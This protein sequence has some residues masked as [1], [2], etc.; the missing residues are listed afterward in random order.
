[1]VIGYTGLPGSGKTYRA[2]Q[3]AVEAM[4]AGR[5]VYANFNI[6]GSNK[7]KNLEEIFHV[8]KG[9]IIIDEINLVCPSR[10]WASFPPE[11]AYFW[12]QT[13]KMGLDIIW[14]AQ[15]HDRVD[16][17]VRE[18]SNW[19]WVH[20]HQIWKIHTRYCFLPEH[21]GKENKK[22]YYFETFLIKKKIYKNYDTFQMIDISDH[23]GN[24]SK[25]IRRNESTTK[26]TIKPA[27][28]AE[29]KPVT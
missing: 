8:R 10:F 24:Q 7:F 4:Q 17:I 28:N 29:S 20:Y 21:V 12:S 23:I 16:K 6:T 27:T 15:H 18:I 1:M 22:P 25:N 26:P 14:T 19:I 2:V 3:Y 13:R 5:E 9:V 11:L